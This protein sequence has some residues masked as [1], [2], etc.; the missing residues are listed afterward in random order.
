VAPPRIE[1]VGAIYHVNSKAVDG[2]KLFVD[3][4]DRALFLRMLCVEAR[5]SDWCVLAYSLMTTHF[6]LLLQLRKPS[7]S[8]G[9]QRL[10]SCYAR[11]YNKRHGRRGALWQRRYFDTIV[12]T[13]G[14]LYEAIRYISM[15]APRAQ[16]CGSPEE[17]PWC[18]YGAAV[19]MAPPDPLVDE[20]E[21]LRLFGTR[22]TEARQRLRW[23][24]EEADA[25][26]RFGQ[27]RVRLLSDAKK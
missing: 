4:S 14:H 9:F 6:H 21:L 11:I 10:N 7:L 3:E 16:A 13:E 24:V 12:E 19:G 25:R 20:V 27:T 22:T 15:N 8:S 17:W 5:R 1:I 23:F 26:A 18:G 2:T